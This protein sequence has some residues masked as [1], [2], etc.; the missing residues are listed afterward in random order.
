MNIQVQC[1][2]IAI[3]TLIWYFYLRQ[4]PL[5]LA[6]EKLFLITLGVNSFCLIMDIVS[7]VAINYQNYISKFLLALICKTYIVSL[8]WVGYFGLIYSHSDF[9]VTGSGRIIKNKIYTVI[10]LVATVLIYSLPIHYYL[11]G[12]TVYTYGPS[13]MATYFFAILF[14][15]VTL[16]GVCVKGRDES[17]AQKSHN[18][19][20]VYLD[21]RC[22]DAVSQCQ[23]VV[24]RLRVS[25]EYGDS[26]L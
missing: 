10:V 9:K 2:G 15:L 24:G 14:V 13:C 20:D 5:G 16:F 19:M 3:L 23:F 12:N 1:C 25:A 18:C 26:V 22:C 17:Q 11:D 4:K 21:C 7:V 6:S 8:V